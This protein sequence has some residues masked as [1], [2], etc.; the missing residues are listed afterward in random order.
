MEYVSQCV[1]TYSCIECPIYLKYVFYVGTHWE[2][3]Y[4]TVFWTS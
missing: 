4:I 1:Y 2:C 3:K